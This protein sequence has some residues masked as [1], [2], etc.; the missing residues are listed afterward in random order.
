MRRRLTVTFPLAFL[1]LL[2]FA[3]TAAADGGI[4]GLPG[5]EPLATPLAPVTQAVTPVTDA[6]KPV[7]DGGAQPVTTQAAGDR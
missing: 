4:L 2:V 6:V 7:T 3:G 1:G 5:T